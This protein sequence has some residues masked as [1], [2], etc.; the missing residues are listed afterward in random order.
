M[1]ENI[2]NFDVRGLSGVC[3]FSERRDLVEEL[4]VFTLKCRIVQKVYR[5][6]HERRN[7]YHTGT[8]Q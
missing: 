1:L 4:D 6:M 5:A 3:S 7:A 2:D 8:N